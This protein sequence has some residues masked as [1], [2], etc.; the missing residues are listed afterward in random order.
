[1]PIDPTDKVLRNEFGIYNLLRTRLRTV[2][3][4]QECDA[5]DDAIKNPAWP[6]IKNKSQSGRNA[7]IQPYH[8][9][10]VFKEKNIF[11]NPLR[12]FAF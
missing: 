10:T 2:S 1:M 8:F 6:Q 4:A 11:Y 12:G 3:T 5:R 7:G 9:E